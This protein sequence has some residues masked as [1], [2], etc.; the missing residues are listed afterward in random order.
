MGFYAYNFSRKFFIQ[1]HNKSVGVGMG[2]LGKKI[3]RSDGKAK[4]RARFNCNKPKKDIIGVQNKSPKAGME[5]E[6]R[7]RN[8]R[9][10]GLRI[11]RE[12]S[13]VTEQMRLFMT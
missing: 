5:V 7:A 11:N 1:D 2:E 12:L 6:Q 9:V 13:A 8:L 4:L 3:P 10:G